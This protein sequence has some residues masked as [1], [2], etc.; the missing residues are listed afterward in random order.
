MVLE[1]SQNASPPSARGISNGWTVDSI[2][3]TTKDFLFLKAN[4]AQCKY[5]FAC[6]YSIQDSL[7]FGKR[8]FSDRYKYQIAWNIGNTGPGP[9][10]LDEVLGTEYV[11]SFFEFE[12]GSVGHLDALNTSVIFRREG[13]LRRKPEQRK[14]EAHLDNYA[15]LTVLPR[16]RPIID[17]FGSI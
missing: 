11:R 9:L 12:F 3:T 8:V 16:V 5:E 7:F 4:R 15:A 1:S 2:G 6:R 10:Q 17:H 13:Y 14:R